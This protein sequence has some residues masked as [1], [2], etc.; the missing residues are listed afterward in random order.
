MSTVSSDSDT[1]RIPKSTGRKPLGLHRQQSSDTHRGSDG[2]LAEVPRYL[3]TDGS[4][5]DVNS[6]GRKDS[7]F[8]RVSQYGRQTR[9]HTAQNRKPLPSPTTIDVPGDTYR[10][11]SPGHSPNKQPGGRRQSVSATG[12]LTRQPLV[13]QETQHHV[14]TRPRHSVAGQQQKLLRR[15]SFAGNVSRDIQPR[16]RGITHQSHSHD[17]TIRHSII[18]G[19]GVPRVTPS[20]SLSSQRERPTGSVL[21]RFLQKGRQLAFRGPRVRNDGAKG[22]R[23]STITQGSSAGSSPSFAHRAFHI[24]HSRQDSSSY[25]QMLQELRNNL[26]WVD[27]VE[28]LTAATVSADPEVLTQHRQSCTELTAALRH[29]FSLSVGAGQNIQTSLSQV[30][31]SHAVLTPGGPAGSGMIPSLARVSMSSAFSDGVFTFSRNSQTNKDGSIFGTPRT[32]GT[33]RR[34]APPATAQKH[35]AGGGLAQLDFS[36]IKLRRLLSSGMRWGAE[37]EQLENDCDISLEK[38][39]ETDTAF[40]LESYLDGFNKRHFEFVESQFADLL[41]APFSLLTYTGPILPQQSF[42]DL[43]ISAWNAL[44]DSNLHLADTAGMMSV[45]A[46][47]LTLKTS[48]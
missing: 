39:I 19:Q 11:A 15:T 23:A 2:I 10:L 36:S 18:S 44:L 20:G 16:V 35:K 9:S 45:R 46:C 26:P 42:Q 21:S 8:I 41:H 37:E 4:F 38:L 27:I 32:F 31:L 14:R 24:S 33:L 34:A 6:T 17:S 12:L 47:L 5:G 43:R 13:P 22:K 28:H 48:A 40:S 7:V 1:S 3:S 29:M 30:S 25:K